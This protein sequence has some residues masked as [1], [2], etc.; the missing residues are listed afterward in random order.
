MFYPVLNLKIFGQA[1]GW[2]IN[3]NSLRTLNDLAYRLIPA[4]RFGSL[5]GGSWLL[6]VQVY[7]L[8]C[9]FRTRWSD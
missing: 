1:F 9:K 4:A 6:H 5:H 2:R 3:A 7:G 8:G